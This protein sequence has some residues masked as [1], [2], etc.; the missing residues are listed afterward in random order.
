M[1][2]V[3]FLANLGLDWRRKRKERKDVATALYQEVANRAGRCAH[4]YIEP[5]RHPFGEATKQG[6]RSIEGRSIPGLVKFLPQ[7]PVIYPRLAEKLAFIDE[8]ALARLID[9]YYHHLAWGRD[10]KIYVNEGER[11]PYNTPCF[12]C[13]DRGCT[14]RFDC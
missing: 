9:F 1:A 12:H 8:E 6:V 11:S 4:D 3:S 10:L 7:D 13:G 2:A 14:S 5:W